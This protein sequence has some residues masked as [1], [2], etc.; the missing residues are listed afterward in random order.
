[1]KDP[2]G[3]TRFVGIGF[4]R[5]SNLAPEFLDAIH[6]STRRERQM[7]V[8][9]QQQSDWT[10]LSLKDGQTIEVKVGM[11]KVIDTSLAFG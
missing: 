7:K 10:D 8:L 6:A 2:K 11:T 3:H 9:E 1:M 4:T 5:E